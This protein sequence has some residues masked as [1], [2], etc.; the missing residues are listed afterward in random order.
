MVQKEAE[1][2]FKYKSLEIEV[3]L[4]WKCKTKTVPVVVGATGVISNALAGFIKGIPGKISI[5]SIQKTAVLGT[6][7]ILRKVLT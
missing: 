7:A 1:K 6:A 3:Q 5:A 4:M 2:R